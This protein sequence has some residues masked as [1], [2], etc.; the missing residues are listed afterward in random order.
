MFAFNRIGMFSNSFL[1]KEF[2]FVSMYMFGMISS[3]ASYDLFLY[4]QV[5]QCSEM[6]YT[7]ALCNLY[8]DIAQYLHYTRMCMCMC[9]KL[10]RY[11]Y[12]C[13]CLWI[14]VYDPVWHSLA[15]SDP[16]HDVWMPDLL[17]KLSCLFAHHEL[18]KCLS[19]CV[20]MYQSFCLYVC[21]MC[22]CVH[23]LVKPIIQ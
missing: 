22:I 20:C 19:I 2:W 21:S 10:Y 1:H 12:L 5:W 11:L 23:G 17:W 13:L 6:S 16:Q 18:E 8:H 4:G 15:H 14:C 7:H 9:S 3:Y